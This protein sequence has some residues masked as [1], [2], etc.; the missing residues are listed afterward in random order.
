MGVPARVAGRP[1]PT[2]RADLEHGRLPDPVVKAIS[3][4]LAQQSQLQERVRQLEKALLQLEPSAL[5]LPVR[6]PVVAAV[7]L[8]QCIREALQEVIDPEAGVSV[9]ELGLIHN[10]EVDGEQVRIRVFIPTPECPFMDYLLNQIQR[11]T[12]CI[13]GIKAVEVT[14]LDEPRSSDMLSPSDQKESTVEGPV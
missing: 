10:I 3:E 1:E 14:L 4:L 13:N 5:A 7:D 12:E 6:P 11:R 2:R 9:V 8:A